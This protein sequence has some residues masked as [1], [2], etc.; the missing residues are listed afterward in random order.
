MVRITPIVKVVMVLLSLK[1]VRYLLL[2]R[3]IMSCAIR[4][5]L[6]TRTLGL[7]FLWIEDIR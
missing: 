4:M 3:P 7:N 1:M 5:M 6:Y 2:S